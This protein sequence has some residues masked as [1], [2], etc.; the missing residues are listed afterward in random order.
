[1]R[2]L[3]TYLFFR[4]NSI[5]GLTFFFLLLHNFNSESKMF[6]LI[7]K[8]QSKISEK[9]FKSSVDKQNND[10]RLEL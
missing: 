2:R 10:Q 5:F 1:M 8:P 7:S 3:I 6:G 9:V 4:S